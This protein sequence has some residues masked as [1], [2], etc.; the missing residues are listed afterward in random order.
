MLIRIGYDISFELTGF[1][2]MLLLLHVRP[3]QYHFIQNEQVQVN[4]PASAQIFLDQFGNQ[5][6]RFLAAPGL[7]QLRNDAVVEV[8]GRADLVDLSARQH[9]I[10]ELPVDKLPYLMASRYCEVDKLMNFAWQTFGATPPG[11]PRVQ[12][13]CTFVHNHIQFGYQFARNTMSAHDV[14]VE[15]KGVCRDFTHLAIT[16]CKC[17]GIPARYATGYLGDIGV[18]ADPA[19][20]DFSAWFE[21][22]LSNM[23]YTFDARHNTPRIGRIAMA[24]GHDASDA[25]LTTS[26]GLT[27]LKSFKVWTHQA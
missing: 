11:Y 27:T 20:M 8:D 17:L 15:R 10:H 16:L 7:L 24:Y 13:V 25:A 19:P 21:V 5:A 9:P 1:T 22:Y 3:Y 26:F 6:M 14:F 23:W 4:P 18:P 12:A 2:P